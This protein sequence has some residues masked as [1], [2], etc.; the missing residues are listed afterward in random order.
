[1][2]LPGFQLLKQPPPIENFFDEDKL[3]EVYEAEVRK[4][5]QAHTGQHSLSCK[6][7]CTAK[8]NM[9]SDVRC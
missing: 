5:V 7:D 1:M 2:L 6:G 9:R 3:K 4:L 8:A